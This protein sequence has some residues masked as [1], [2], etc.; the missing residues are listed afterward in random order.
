MIEIKPIKTKKQYQQ[1]LDWVDE[2]FDKKVK[3][4]TKEGNLLQV[5]L[6]LIKNYE[7]EYYQVP[8][9]DPIEVLKLKMEEKGI[10]N[11]DLV[12]LLGSKSNV[13]NILIKS[14]SLTL[15]NA[16]VLHRKLG[17]PADVLLS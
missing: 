11:K 13:S 5:V 1:Y 17:V 10:R 16:K 3:P 14:K 2:I 12:G 9:P 4:G 15:E 8:I 6:I 7:D